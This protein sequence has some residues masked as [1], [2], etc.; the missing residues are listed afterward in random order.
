MHIVD[1]CYRNLVRMFGEE[2]INATVGYINADVR[3]YGLTETSMNLEG[4]DR[5]QRLITSYQKLHA[6]RAAKVD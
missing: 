6:W 1:A 3:F 5:H 2:K 4:I